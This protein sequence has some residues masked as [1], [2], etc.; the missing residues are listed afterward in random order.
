M[1]DRV[2]KHFRRPA[3]AAR[4]EALHSPRPWPWA[5]RVGLTPRG[6]AWTA[7][8]LGI[9]S[10]P[11]VVLLVVTEQRPVE[12]WWDFSMGLGFSGLALIGVQ[13]VLTARFRRLSSPFGI[14]VI[15]LVHRYFAWTA[16]LL[17]YGHFGILWLRYEEALGELN[18]LTAR[19]E[20][21]AGRVAL[22]SF[23]LAVFTSEWRKRLSLE[24][25]L[26]RYLHAALAT[27]GLLAAVGHILGVG[28]YTALAPKTGLWL[29]LTLVSVG[30]IA[31]LRLVKPWL[32][33]QAA[34]R[35]VSIQ[36]EG[37]GSAWTVAVEPCGHAGLDSFKPGQFAWLTARSSPYLLREHPFSIA[38]PPE[39]LPRLEFGIKG[40]GAFSKA[41]GDLKPGERVYLDGPYGVFSV[42]T[43]PDASG[44]VFVAGGIG[45]TPV[46]SMLRS[47]AARR[48]SQP[49]WLFYG[50]P[51]CDEI[52]YDEELT[53][54]ASRLNL[55]RVDVLQ[56]APPG[57]DG[58]T[59]KLTRAI[60]E[61]HLPADRRGLAFFLCGPPPMI[62]AVRSELTDL[63]V[64][65]T[66]IRS[67]IFELA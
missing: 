45:I 42:D 35:V 51:S 44:Y 8:L 48:A 19:W 60:L 16:L 41:I 17:V 58:E 5:E 14:D 15:Y 31:W 18:P 7:A 56:D 1:R 29:A 66:H 22:V 52:I 54:L 55:H 21:T 37:D 24:Y 26:W 40:L 12:F 53:R 32:Q 61:R 13:F 9:V 43:F 3:A 20:L 33:K 23:T 39:A 10:A 6:L 34:Y 62:K 28:N 30:L 2:V 50:N 36:P 4:V 64:P 38:S 65:A 25:G 63:G 49:L 11:V 59:G 46:M 27:V 47:L 67:E 57:W